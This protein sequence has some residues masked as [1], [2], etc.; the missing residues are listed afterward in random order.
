MN[1][2]RQP[3][4]RPIEDFAVIGNCHGAAEPVANVDGWDGHG[5][6]LRR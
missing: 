1:M 2:P 6:E 3:A 4:H 5:H